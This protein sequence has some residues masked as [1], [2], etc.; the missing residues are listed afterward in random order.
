VALSPRLLGHNT[1][2]T[3]NEM[4]SIR[5]ELNRMSACIRKRQIVTARNFSACS[6]CVVLT[7]VWLVELRSSRP[8][9]CRTCIGSPYAADNVGSV[10]VP[11][12]AW[13]TQ[14]YAR[15]PAQRTLAD[16]SRSNSSKLLSVNSEIKIAS[17][18][19]ALRY[20]YIF[21]H[22]MN[23]RKQK[24]WKKIRPQWKK[25]SIMYTNKHHQ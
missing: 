1:E 22:K 2:K 19:S 9:E 14:S 18:N 21:I 8:A 24:K 11:C 17:G 13:T 12:C 7:C 23:D 10:W 25:H 16:K 6:R 15:S 20:I 5:T 4:C 3:K